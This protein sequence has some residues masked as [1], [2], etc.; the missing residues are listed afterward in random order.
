MFCYTADA[1]T[2]DT[3]GA[4]QGASKFTSTLEA[5]RLTL[6]GSGLTPVVREIVSP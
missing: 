4:R 2:F 1:C 6:W 5:A 3:H